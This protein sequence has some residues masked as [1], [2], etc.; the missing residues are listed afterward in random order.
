MKKRVL[1]LLIIGVLVGSTLEAAARLI[2]QYRVLEPVVPAGIGRFDERL[3]W[4]LTPLS[5]GTS[6]RTG[7]EVDYRINSKGLR[8][9]ETTYK[10]PE[11]T[12]RIVL[13]GDSRT[14]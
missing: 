8:G 3:G 2:L 13:L 6:R 11:G 4:A 10:K 9:R 1:L 12:F 5:H 7:Y 14:F